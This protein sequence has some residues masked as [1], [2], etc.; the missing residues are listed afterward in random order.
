MADGAMTR[1]NRGL[2][3]LFSVG[4]AIAVI[5]SVTVGLAWEN[6]GIVPPAE[7]GRALVILIPVAIAGPLLC[8]IIYRPLVPIFPIFLFFLFAFR[9]VNDLIPQIPLREEISIAVLL[10][11]LVTIFLRTRKFE[12]VA[13]SRAIFGIS[14][15][16][17]VATLAVAAPNL[18]GGEDVELDNSFFI[19]AQIAAAE[20]TAPESLP[21][22]IYIVPDR[23][24]SGNAL[25]S[26]FGYDNSAF[27]DQLRKRG[28]FVDPNAWA[29]YPKTAQSLASTLNS[30]Y[31]DSLTTAYGSDS[32]DQR[33]MNRMIED[34]HA[35]RSLRSLGYEFYNF[36]NWWEP[37]RINRYANENYLGYEDGED[38]AYWQSEFERILWL[39]TPFPKLAE[40]FGKDAA[41]RE[42][43]RIKRQLQYLASIGNGPKP[44]FA[45]VHL[46]V[47]HS[48][49]LTDAGGTCLE[50]EIDFPAED[51][52]W[53]AFKAAYVEYLRFFNDAAI[54][55]F[56]QQQ[57][58]RLDNGR[59]L[60]F[61]IQSDEGPFPKV[62]REEGKGYDFF[63]LSPDALRTKMGILNAIHLP[64]GKYDPGMTARTPIN[65]W[66]FIFHH[67]TGVPA[68]P[69]PDRL[70]IFPDRNHIYE[71]RDVS[72][73]LDDSKEDLDTLVDP[74][75]K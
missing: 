23:Y 13:I 31:L 65:N 44:V 29:N 7:V 51:V 34:N 28:F 59:E 27:Y 12:G 47:P 41:A 36:G 3:I 14:T 68:E 6:I 71:F 52:S 39:K 56:D 57:K 58:R 21:D 62:I 73:L 20:G 63:A 24:A 69:L 33:P 55:I 54:G 67:I 15:A 8:A 2:E 72:G 25:L 46:V 10:S 16:M 42:C 66:R 32:A 60:I 37:T 4:A 35:Q 45:F 38:T 61:V 18:I 1:K 64:G 22:I 75:G 19:R 26:E 74:A 11:A 48:P 30:S 70:L 43:R 50:K 17:A 40:Q 53:P 5:V 9:A 49:I